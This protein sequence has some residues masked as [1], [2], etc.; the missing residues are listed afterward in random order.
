MPEA[1]AKLGDEPVE[2]IVKWEPPK[3]TGQ[4]E[5]NVLPPPAGV[6]TH[7]LV[8]GALDGDAI[9]SEFV[10]LT[11][12]RELFDPASPVEAVII[13]MIDALAVAVEIDSAKSKLW[14]RAMAQ[15]EAEGTKGSSLTKFSPDLIE[16]E[17][18]TSGG[19]KDLV[20]WVQTSNYRLE[21]VAN[22]RM[23]QVT[24]SL[25]VETVFGAAMQGNSALIL[26]LAQW[27]RKAGAIKNFQTAAKEI[28]AERISRAEARLG[29]P[30]D[31]LT[32]LYDLPLYEYILLEQFQ[33]Y[34]RGDR[35]DY[36]FS[37]DGP[38]KRTGL[39]KGPDCLA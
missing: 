32:F 30:H 8:M 36:V 9:T 19:S 38:P 1:E 33:A 12:Q 39:G 22:S 2:A 37:I 10:N 21:E 13:G 16:L 5:T 6:A 11:A 23:F 17:L 18:M 25:T 26:K 35:S 14:S 4:A 7:D 3:L 20:N 28:L 15:A 24:P 27:V 31:P 34:M 29:V